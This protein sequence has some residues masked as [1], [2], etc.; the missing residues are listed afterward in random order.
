LIKLLHLE[1]TDAF[2][3][4]VYQCID[5][6]LFTGFDVDL[7]MQPVVQYHIRITG[8]ARNWVGKVVKM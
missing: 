2:G 3:K 7:T 1:V 8:K 5:V 4:L 6:S